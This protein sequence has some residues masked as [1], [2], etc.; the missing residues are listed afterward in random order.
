MMKRVLTTAAVLAGVV[1]ATTAAQ[2]Q[3]PY[4]DSYARGEMER[5]YP[6]GGGALRGAALG[7]LGGAAIASITGGN[8][9]TGAGIGAGAGLVVGSAAW[10][11][12][13]Q[14]VFN[15]AY[16]Y[17]VQYLL[18]SAPPPSAPAVPP[19]AFAPPTPY[20]ARTTASSQNVRSIPQVSGS[21][22]LFTVNP[23]QVFQM[24]VC[25]NPSPGWC[26]IDYMGYQGY[27]SRNYTVPVS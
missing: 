1:M 19:A 22:I 16:Q 27:L 26:Y 6:T 13:R 17:C 4:C 5:Q 25:D 23:T 3:V 12:R 14:Q 2:A 8:V 21:T 15:S 10:Q 9:G 11:Q 20:W 7:A 18:A 24:L